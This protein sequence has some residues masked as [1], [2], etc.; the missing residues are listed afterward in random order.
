MIICTSISP[1][2]KNK[3]AQADCIGSWHQFG[4]VYSFNTKSEIE[5]LKDSYEEV[6]FVEI[7]RTVKELFGKPLVPINCFIDY[8][9]ERKEDLVLINSDIFISYLPVFKTDGVS[10]LTRNDYTDGID[11]STAFV[12]GYDLFHI[13]FEFLKI[14]PPMLYGLGSTFWDI[15]IP[16]RALK[17]NVPLYWSQDKFIFHKTHENQYAYSDWLRTGEYFKWEFGIEQQIPVPHALQ[18]IMFKLKS[19]SIK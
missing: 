19:E 4:K 11:H 18:S 15:S 6:E 13:P 1:Y 9:I 17:N 16:Y 12:H 3:E 8:A 5:L 14:Y 2:H 10:M 7:H